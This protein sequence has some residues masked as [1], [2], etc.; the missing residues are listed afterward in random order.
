ME[1]AAAIAR[2][3]V[4]DVVREP[5]KPWRPSES[6]GEDP[7]GEG[8]PR[9]LL[10]LVRLACQIRHYSYRTEQAYCGWVKRFCRYHRDDGP[11]GRGRPRHPSTMREPE[12]VAFLTH[13]AVDRH[14]AASTQNQALAALL[15]LYE[16]VLG[17]PLG[18]LDAVEPDELPDGM[19]QL[20]WA[21]RP[22]RLP[23]VLT[24]EEVEAVLAE[25]S[26][27]HRLAGM[28][29]YGSGLRLRECLRLRVKD[30]DFGY[31]HLTVRDGKGMKDR[32]TVFPEALHEPMERHLAREK[33][34]HEAELEEGTAAVSMP[35]A[36]ANKYPNAETEWGWRYVFPASRPSEDPRSGREL[37]HHLAPS[38]VQ[39][40]VRRASRRASDLMGL[41]KHVTPHVFRHSFA[42]HLLERGADIRTVQ[43]LLGHKSVRT[44]MVYTHVVNRGGL[45]VISPLDG[46]RL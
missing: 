44:T 26:G 21:K 15:F 27:T 36:L 31:G 9:K 45:G 7:T 5:H 3:V 10:D 13:L 14:V 34:R 24:R 23:V 18:D 25:L 22:K 6:P 41:A 12:V 38:A 11:G 17:E 37:L 30:L 35:G 32:V 1:P 29:L 20:V 43:E 28:L 19:G 33:L 46:M 4:R 8:R 16:A 39:K 40:A 42:T 2:D